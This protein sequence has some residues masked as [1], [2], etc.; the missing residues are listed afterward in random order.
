MPGR[1]FPSP[2]SPPPISNCL[3]SRPPRPDDASAPPPPT[4]RGPKSFLFP[5]R[6]LSVRTSDDDVRESKSP[7][8]SVGA[9]LVVDAAEEEAAAFPVGCDKLLFSGQVLS[10][11][12]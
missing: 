4:P 12:T 2:L 9:P 8:A 11:A 3:P 7:A 6:P 10:E 1:E 5:P